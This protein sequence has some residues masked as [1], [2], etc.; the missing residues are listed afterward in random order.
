MP[1]GILTRFIVE[2]H[3]WIEEQELVWKNAVVSMIMLIR[4]WTTRMSIL[5]ITTN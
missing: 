3:P 4:A 5:S 2:T 1:K